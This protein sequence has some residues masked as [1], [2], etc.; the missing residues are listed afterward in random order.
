M[1]TRFLHARLRTATLH[2]DHEGQATLVNLLLRNYLHYSLFEQA[3]KLVSK[4]TFPESASNNEWARFL[5]Y[6]GKCRGEA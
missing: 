5:F 6:L 3:D 2:S 4:S 1:K